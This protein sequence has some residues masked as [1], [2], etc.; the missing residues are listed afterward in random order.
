M[1]RVGVVMKCGAWH[2]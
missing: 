2:W 1:Y